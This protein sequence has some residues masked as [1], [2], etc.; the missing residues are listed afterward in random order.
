MAELDG[1]YDWR[2]QRQHH[3]DGAGNLQSKMRWDILDG[4][5]A[6]VAGCDGGVGADCN[7]QAS[8]KSAADLIAAAKGGARQDRLW[9]GRAFAAASGDGDVRVGCW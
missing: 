2:V 1:C 7:N 5:R 6:G 3:D 9:L 4:F 8:F